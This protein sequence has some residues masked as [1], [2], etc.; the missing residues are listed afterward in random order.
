MSS[1]PHIPDTPAPARFQI[2]SRLG[3]LRDT[4]QISDPLRTGA[5]FTVGRSGSN[6]HKAWTKQRIASNPMT[7]IVA[8][9][10][11]A[12][13]T[14]VL[15][16]DE[17][18]IVNSERA[19]SVNGS[20]NPLLPVVDR[21]TLSASE[22]TLYRDALKRLMDSGELLP[23]DVISGRR[24]EDRL[25]EALYLLKTW[26]RM[27]DADGNEIPYSVEM[28]RELLT[29]DTPLE[30]AGV[31]DLVLGVDAWTVEIT[32]DYAHPSL[33]DKT[34]PVKIVKTETVKNAEGVEVYRLTVRYIIPGLTLGLAY[35]LL[36]LKTARDTAA[37]RDQVIEAAGK[38]SVPSSDSI[39]SS[40]DG[41][42]SG[43]PAS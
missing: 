40:G 9:S 24:D 29:N 15:T 11:L 10:M 18:E 4:V 3:A 17:T 22:Q 27:P 43:A 41:K 33:V 19:S 39:S 30:G 42:S 5:M 8:E 35:Q 34:R 2:A 23:M 6:S 1:A 13:E 36:I 12:T 28:A 14:V 37:F 31:D 16:P 25:E 26:D 20:S 21:L 7:R 32:E 38:N